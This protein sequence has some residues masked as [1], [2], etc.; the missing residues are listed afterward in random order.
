MHYNINNVSA[1]LISFFKF[2]IYEN[3]WDVHVWIKI[4]YTFLFTK[5]LNIT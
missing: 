3:V 1:D 2:L 4:Q 5:L